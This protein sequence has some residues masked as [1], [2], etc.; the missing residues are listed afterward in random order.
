MGPQVLAAAGTSQD[1]GALRDT[2]AHVQGTTVCSQSTAPVGFRVKGAP[3][4]L[5]ELTGQMSFFMEGSDGLAA[6]GNR[7]DPKSSKWEQAEERVLPTARQGAGCCFQHL[8]HPS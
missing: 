4:R 3:R 2:A 5:E 6:S 7:A 8:G 1:L